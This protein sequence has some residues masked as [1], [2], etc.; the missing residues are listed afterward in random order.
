MH[1]HGHL[2]K[3]GT[4]HEQPVVY[5]L[6]L[7]SAAATQALTE[8]PL[9][10]LLGQH[11][12]LHFTGRINCIHCGRSTRKS[13]SQGYCYPCFTRLAECDTCL[14]RPETCHYQQGTCR[15]PGWGQQHCFR[16][17]LVYLAN[18]TGLKVGITRETGLATRWM[19]QGAVAALPLFRVQDRL[20]SGRIES[21][22]A[23]ELKDRTAWQAM[24][25]NQVQPL[26]LVQEAQAVV[27]RFEP[28]LQAMPDLDYQLLV[29]Q[30]LYFEY[31]VLAYPDKVRSLNPEKTPCIEGQLMGIKGQYLLLDTGV[32]NLRKHTGYEVEFS[33][34]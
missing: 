29:E 21:L 11:I 5:Q 15:D 19:D 18:T 7:A 34:H 9:N 6:R 32:I 25:K 33:C 17:H 23:T 22:L 31:P 14:V 13:F 1:L 12:R 2:R 27:A 10:P 30:P 26:D 4:S 16:S 28:V 8:L 24:L 20:A 3:L